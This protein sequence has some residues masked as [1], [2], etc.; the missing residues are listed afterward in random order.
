[1]RRKQIGKHLD[2]REL[3]GP[4][5]LVK[6]HSARPPSDDTRRKLR[7]AASVACSVMRTTVWE[8]DKVCLF[9]RDEKALMTGVLDEHFGFKNLDGLKSNRDGNGK[10]VHTKARREWLG[11]IRRI[12][13]SVSFHLNTGM[14]LLDTD[15]GY[16]TIIGDNEVDNMDA[17]WSNSFIRDA[18]G[19]K[20]LDPADPNKYHVGTA[21][22][23]TKRAVGDLIEAYA[24]VDSGGPVHVS[25][26]LA[27]SMSALEFARIIIHEASHT[28]CGTTDV[29]YAH[30]GSSYSDEKPHKMI[31]N[32]DSFAYAA[33]SLGAKVL[34]DHG[35]LQG[36]VYN[37]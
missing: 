33:V 34:H 21:M 17:S 19:Q 23:G 6:Y 4:K 13:L 24:H 26:E 8:I 20:T 25:F 14:Y 30:A 11:L 12:M 16:R 5:L 35:S 2:K 3:I 37:P 15:A 7:E 27:K 9:R 10:L 32:A 22:L 18:A 1:M 36:A 31:S 29:W 28:F